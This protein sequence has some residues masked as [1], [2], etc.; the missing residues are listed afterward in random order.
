MNYR[1]RGYEPRGLTW[2]PYPA[3]RNHTPPY[4]YKLFPHSPKANSMPP[5]Q[6][7]PQQRIQTLLEQARQTHPTDPAQAHR[8]TQLAHRIATRTRTRPPKHI[9]QQTCPKCHTIRTATTSRTRIRQRR[10]PH[11]A[12][13]CLHCGHTERTP[14]KRKPR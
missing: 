2:L 7:I 14:T 13:T 5:R 6:S 11:I 10:E 9:K 4:S 1:P 12:T 8:Y 3:S